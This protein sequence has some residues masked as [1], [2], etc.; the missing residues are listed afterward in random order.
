MAQLS[1]TE[2]VCRHS[3]SESVDREI[4]RCPR[5]GGL[6]VRVEHGTVNGNG[7]HPQERGRL[8]VVRRGALPTS[9]A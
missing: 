9:Y 7:H 4:P 6:W 2:P 5:C 8:L 1:C 3:W